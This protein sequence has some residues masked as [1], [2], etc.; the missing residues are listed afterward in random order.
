MPFDSRDTFASI[1]P[2]SLSNIQVLIEEAMRQQGNDFDSGALKPYKV[3]SRSSLEIIHA[4]TS[5]CERF[6]FLLCFLSCCLMGH[7]G[8]GAF[9]FKSF[10][11]FP[12][13]CGLETQITGEHLF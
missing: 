3:S 5:Q 13:K 4:K 9:D 6:V 7:G 8:R 12:G 2:T 11:S 10:F 1:L